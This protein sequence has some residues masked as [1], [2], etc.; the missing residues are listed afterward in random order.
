MARPRKRK[1]SGGGKPKKVK[2]ELIND[3]D[4][5]LETNDVKSENCV[6][7]DTKPVK[8]GK[9]VKITKKEEKDDYEDEEVPTAATFITAFCSLDKEGRVEALKKLIG[10]FDADEIDKALEIMDAKL[11][12]KVEAEEN[13]TDIKNEEIDVK[14]E[15]L[16]QSVLTL[17]LVFIWRI[18]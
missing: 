3:D 12:D 2:V 15:S 4:G 14:E 18:P 16:E 8:K 9:R 13:D 17:E 10:S 1:P 7:V 6:N 11:A 5:E